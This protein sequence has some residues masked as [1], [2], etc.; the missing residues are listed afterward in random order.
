MP[1]GEVFV[2]EPFAAA[3][4]LENPAFACAYVGNIPSAK[5]LGPMRMYVL[6][7]E[8]RAKSEFIQSANLA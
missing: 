6:K 8:G 7:G 4:M 3:L 2:S 1:D 5:G